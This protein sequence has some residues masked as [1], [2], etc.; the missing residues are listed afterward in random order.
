[1][2]LRA[3]KVARGCSFRGKKLKRCRTELKRCR[4]KSGIYRTFLPF[5][6]FSS[7]KSPTKPQPSGTAA[8]VSVVVAALKCARWFVFLFRGAWMV[9]AD[10]PSAV[11]LFGMPYAICGVMLCAECPSSHHCLTMCGAG[12]C[13]SFIAQGGILGMSRHRPRSGLSFLSRLE[14]RQRC[15]L[16]IV[17]AVR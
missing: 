10:K 1:M 11:I 3:E 14:W 9:A 5:L 12:A 6:P 4:T 2:L 17:L 15:G 13:R 7:W 16:P 8:A